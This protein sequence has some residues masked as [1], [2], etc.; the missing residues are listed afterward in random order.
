MTS[1]S[2]LFGLIT[3]TDRGVNQQGAPRAPNAGFLTNSVDVNW[4]Q[5][6]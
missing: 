2:S 3:R 1:S 4:L 6:N 5:M